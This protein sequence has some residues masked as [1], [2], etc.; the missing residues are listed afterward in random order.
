MSE[1]ALLLN[2]HEEVSFTKDTFF[3]KGKYFLLLASEP[4]LLVD[5]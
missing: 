1:S 5:V 2:V 3:K 4:L